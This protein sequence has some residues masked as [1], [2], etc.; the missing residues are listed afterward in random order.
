ML[1]S[2]GRGSSRV[3]G[4]TLQPQP[5]PLLLG[6]YHITQTSWAGDLVAHT[7]LHWDTRSS[8]KQSSNWSSWLFS[9]SSFSF[10]LILK[11]GCVRALS[12]LTVSAEGWVYICSF[13]RAVE[14][15]WGIIPCLP[16]CGPVNPRSSRLCVHPAREHW[17]GA[18][19]KSDLQSAKPPTSISCNLRRLGA[20][21]DVAPWVLTGGITCS[22]V[23][24]AV[25]I[26][27]HIFVLV[28]A[29]RQPWAAGGGKWSVQCRSAMRFL[30]NHSPLEADDKRQ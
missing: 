14:S 16:C 30:R 28:K 3:P 26:Y 4:S 5:A 29:A 2:A 23:S 15:L 17:F 20:A 8:F 7:S 25:G 12:V 13:C 18:G 27:G 9:F 19:H 24:G 1:S 11:A 6:V 21:R 22:R 10:S